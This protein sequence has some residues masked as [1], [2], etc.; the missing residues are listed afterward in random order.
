MTRELDNNVE[1]ILALEALFEN[2][3]FSI[4]KDLYEKYEKEE[5]K[6]QFFNRDK[7]L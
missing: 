3:L 6:T 4:P 5:Q 7:F 1:N 2:N